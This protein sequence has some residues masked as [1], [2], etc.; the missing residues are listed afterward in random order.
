MGSG[1]WTSASYSTYTANTRGCSVDA[2][3]TMDFSAQE[4]FVNRHIDARLDPKNVTRQC[5]DSAE[6][7]QTVPVI[8]ALDVTGSMGG[9]AVKVAQKLNDIITNVFDNNE[10]K[11]VEFCVMGIGDLYYDRAPVQISQFES[12]IRIAEQL[13]AIYFESGGG[14]NKSESYS[15]AWYMGLNHCDLD[16]WKRGQK[17]LII[18]LGDELPNPCLPTNTVKSIIGDTVQGDVETKELLAEARNRFEIYHFSVDDRETA[19]QSYKSR[20]NLDK[21]WK[22]MLGDEYYDVVTLDSLDRKITDT[23]IKFATNSNDIIFTSS[24]VAPVIDEDGKISW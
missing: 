16:C 20:Y 13:D 17:G 12:D 8:L 10:V 1:S 15:A 14:G 11:D 6:H 21:Q 24:A 23:I 3:K 7:P 5:H 4:M 22:E 19:Y 2:F 9:A 18:T